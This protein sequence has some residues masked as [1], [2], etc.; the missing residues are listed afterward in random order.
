MI[1]VYIKAASE[2][3]RMSSASGLVT[4]MWNVC[5]LSLPLPP[6]PEADADAGNPTNHQHDVLDALLR[7]VEKEL[8]GSFELHKFLTSDLGAPLPLHI[9]LSRPLSLSTADKD[10]FFDRLSSSL[11]T[12]GI[13]P[14]KVVP[15]GLGWYKSPDSDRTFLILRVTAH[16]A[17]AN[18]MTAPNPELLALLKRCN[19]VAATFNEKPLYQQTQNEPVGSAFHVSVA[20]SFGLPSDEASLRSLKV[21]KTKRFSEVRSWEI[22]VSAVKVKIGNVVHHVPLRGRKMAG[23]SSV[24]ER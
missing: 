9:S 2:E 19:T 13:A 16:D 21:L 15:R 17:S 3:R 14:F 11:Q 5:V 10:S 8:E 23:E 18:D 1:Q 6:V 24:F 4:S 22:D 20:W 7:D 12:S